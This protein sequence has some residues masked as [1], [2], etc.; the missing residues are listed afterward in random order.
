M[1]IYGRINELAGERTVIM[2]THRLGAIRSASKIIV[3]ED[4]K[5]VEM[6]NFEQLMKKQGRF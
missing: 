6:G 5:I 3:M 4:G 2:A 1:A